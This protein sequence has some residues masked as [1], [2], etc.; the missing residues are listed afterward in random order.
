MPSFDW[1]L[2]ELPNVIG[3]NGEG[4]FDI[5]TFIR[6]SGVDEDTDLVDAQ[7]WGA[8]QV[9]PIEFGWTQDRIGVLVRYV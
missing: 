4:V 7:A 1:V 6:R 9:P 8:A 5:D 3:P 2:V